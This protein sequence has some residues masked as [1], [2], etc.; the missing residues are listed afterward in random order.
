GARLA[1]AHSRSGMNRRTTWRTG[2]G[3]LLGCGVISGAAKAQQ[4]PAGHVM[5]D[6]GGKHVMMMTGPLGIS[7]DRMGSGTTWIPD[8]VSLPMHHTMA[9]KWELMSH[10]TAFA[11]YNKQGG[12]RGSDQFGSMNWGML[13]ASRKAGDGLFQ[14]RAM[15]SVEPATVTT[16]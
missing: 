11:Q 10:G 12:D 14:A 7:T 4:H 16:S 6:S 2:L 13:M 15:L 3:V 5:P 1:R 9:G 8:A